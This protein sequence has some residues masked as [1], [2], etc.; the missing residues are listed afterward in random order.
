MSLHAYTCMN[1]SVLFFKSAT[2]GVPL[3]IHLVTCLHGN[4]PSDPPGNPPGDPPGNPPLRMGEQDAWLK[5]G[6][7]RSMQSPC[8]FMHPSSPQPQL[9]N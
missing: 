5:H 8:A 9:L 6:S 3:V 2:P 4:P 7:S 1:V